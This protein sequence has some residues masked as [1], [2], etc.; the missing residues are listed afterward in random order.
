MTVGPRRVGAAALIGTSLLVSC[1]GE[2]DARAGR[3]AFANAR[4]GKPAALE[5][6]AVLGDPDMRGF[7]E[8]TAVEGAKP[9]STEPC[10]D[11]SPGR[12][13]DECVFQVADAMSLSGDVVAVVR[14][15]AS[16]GAFRLD[17]ARHVSVQAY[18][19]E[20]RFS[21]AFEAALAEVAPELDVRG[22]WRLETRHQVYVDLARHRPTF[23]LTDC[24]GAEDVADCE[25]ATA[26]V[27]H[28]R[29]AR[30][31]RAEPDVRRRLCEGA[32]G[33][34]LPVVDEEVRRL[35]LAWVPA[36]ALEA[37]LRGAQVEVCGPPGSAAPGR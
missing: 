20:G 29:W 11:V 1:G 12:W 21:P 18:R 25:R 17:C 10:L 13:R 24:A 35:Q 2:G 14:S 4:A 28:N 7:C 31:A 22:A 6:C 36:P 23:V 19:R 8:Y 27:L 16:A 26:E 15:C 30:L 37:Q 9:T 5:G 33:G 32:A 3:D 34:Q